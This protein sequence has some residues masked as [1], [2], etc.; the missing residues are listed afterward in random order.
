MSPA[1]EKT[2]DELLEA[3]AAHSPAALPEIVDRYLDTLYDFGVRMALDERLASAAVFAALG[4]RLHESERPN[5]IT[6]KP[7]LLGLTR[8]EVLKRSRR[9]AP[10]KG[11]PGAGITAE[12]LSRLPADYPAHDDPALGLWAWPSARGQGPRD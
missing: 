10:G 6:F 12:S 8:D 9:A 7:L 1:E 5:G 11:L 3:L 4:R 2:D